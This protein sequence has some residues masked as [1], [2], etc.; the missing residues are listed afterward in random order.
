MLRNK[1]LSIQVLLCLGAGLVAVIYA[2]RHWSL[3][4]AALVGGIC[5]FYTLVLVGFS[6]RRYRLMK[7]LADEVTCARAARKT[8][9]LDSM[10]EGDLAVLVSEVDKTLNQ[11]QLTG[12]M[13]EAKN[14]ELADYLANISHQLRTP[15]TALTI[16]LELMDDICQDSQVRLKIKDCERLLDR[17]L[18]LVSALLKL[19]RLDA[20]TVE[21]NCQKVS[22]Q[23]LVVGA[24]QPL[25]ASFETEEVEFVCDIDPGCSFTG[26]IA[27][28]REALGNI[29]KNCM[30]HSEPGDKVYLRAYEDML[31]TRIQVEDQGGGIPEKDLPHIFE[32]FYSTSG[33][34]Q[35]NPRGVGIGLALAQAL[36]MEQDGAISAHNKVDDKGDVVGAAFDIVFFKTTV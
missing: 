12:E 11:L 27:W 18:W 16:D 22:V 34:S 7:K 6:I 8:V 23:D 3:E 5:L 9:N 2:W 14:C 10:R 15:L 31:A 32:R 29:L 25:A 35:V 26:D 20:K 36:I 13:L 30:E 28:T 24:F 21:L 17:V 19:A 4:V 1:N 33:K